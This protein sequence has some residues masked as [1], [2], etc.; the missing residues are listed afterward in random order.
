MKRILYLLSLFSIA[1]IV[2]QISVAA[3]NPNPPDVGIQFGY[4]YS[5]LSPHGE[6]ID[7]D[8]GVRV[9]HPL[10]MN[11]QWRPYLMGRW[12]WSDY[13]WYWMSSEPFGWIT[14]HYGR[15][16]FDDYYGWVW[17][18]DDVWGPAWVEW[19]YD[20]DYIGWAPLPPYASFH[21]SF[22]IQFTT[23]WEAPYH[24]WNFVRYHRFGSMIRYRDIE[25]MEH[26]K[27]LIHTARSGGRYDMDHDRI[28]NRGIDRSIIEQR[29]NVRFSRTEIREVTGQSGE[30]M[31]RNG[32]NNRTQRIEF[33][34][35]TR[36]EIQGSIERVEAR[37]GNRELSLDVNKIERKQIHQSAETPQRERQRINESAK[38]RTLRQTPQPQEQQP[39]DRPRNEQRRENRPRVQ[40]RRPSQNSKEMRQELIQ[41]H[42]NKHNPTPPSLQ[43]AHPSRIDMRREGSSTMQSRRSATMQ[44]S[45]RGNSKSRND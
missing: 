15:W 6:W 35:P 20:N 29:G 1:S 40:E 27:R 9:W 41:R 30:R 17:V 34:R 45:N 39:V 25:S 4:F 26:T 3:L 13:G 10:H 31:I 37:R 11:R 43:K 32:G 12:V 5:S 36:E 21:V 2:D 19:R 28:I 8:S 7:M 24:Y 22:G 23:H 16:Y 18:P 14:Y 33:Y 44:R 38:G 42:E